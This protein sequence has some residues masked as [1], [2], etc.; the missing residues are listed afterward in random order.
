[1]AIGMGS[2]MGGAMGGAGGDGWGARRRK[3][4]GAGTVPPS[5][6][7]D[8]RARPVGPVSRAM[9]ALLCVN[10]RVAR[11]SF[12][13]RTQTSLTAERIHELEQQLELAN[14]AAKGGS[15][16]SR[17]G[18]SGCTVTAVRRKAVT[19]IWA[20]TNAIAKAE[21]YAREPTS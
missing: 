7:H 5:R 15:L 20:V 10:E 13:V 1:M 14:A 17:L 12:D 4:R 19:R 11:E 8:V 21:H 6:S 3:R 18:L 9:C 16:S 2:A